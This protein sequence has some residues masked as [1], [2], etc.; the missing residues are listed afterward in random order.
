VWCCAFLARPYLWVR[1]LTPLCLS[2]SLRCAGVTDVRD[3]IRC[4]TLLLI[5]CCAHIHCSHTYTVPICYWCPHILV[6]YIPHLPFTLLTI[7]FCLFNLPVLLHSFVVPRYHLHPH[8]HV[9]PFPHLFTPFA[10][11]HLV[12]TYMCLT[13][14]FYTLP[15]LVVHLVLPTLLSDN[16]LVLLL[17]VFCCLVMA[18]MLL[19]MP[20]VC[21]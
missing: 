2:L 9:M 17:A 18:V 8:T 14:P 6:T 15:S 19:L 4:A 5:R 21:I 13:F 7:A 1:Y 3:V 11:P 12:C 10:T 20:Y 16:N